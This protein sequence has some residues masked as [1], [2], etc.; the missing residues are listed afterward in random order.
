MNII[1]YIA[2]LGICSFCLSAQTVEI[3][4]TAIITDVA[5]ATESAEILARETD[6]TVSVVP[7][8][9]AAMVAVGDFVQGGIVFWLSTDGKHGKVVALNNIAN[10]TWSNVSSGLANGAF[11][12]DVGPAK[13]LGIVAQSGHTG[14]A[15]EKSLAYFY[16]GYDDWYLPTETEGLQISGQLADVNTAIS[17]HGGSAITQFW[18]S[19]ESSGTEVYIVSG[20]GSSSTLKNFVVALVRPVRAFYISD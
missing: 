8:S 16:A 17:S 18:T 7:N 19:T 15:A 6:G 4:G 5:V 20:N 13:T 3:K 14:S 2:L 1:K 9:T 10:R 11:I 12:G